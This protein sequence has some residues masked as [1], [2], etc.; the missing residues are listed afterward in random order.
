MYY[1]DIKDK[2]KDA[3]FVLIGLGNELR[4]N[5]ENVL[6]NSKLYKDKSNIIDAISDENV[7]NT[8][9]NAIVYYEIDN[10]VGNTYVEAFRKLYELI[11]DKNYYIIS[12]LMWE[13]PENSGFSC[14]K[15]VSP[16]GSFLRIQNSENN[17]IYDAKPEYDRIIKKLINN[18]DLKDVLP[19]IPNAFV[20]DDYNEDGYL[21][22]WTEYTKWLER[23]LNQKLF[24][25]EIGTDFSMPSVIRWPFEKAV[26]INNKAHMYR[27]CTRFYQLT[28]E[29]KDKAVGIQEEPIKFIN[30]LCRN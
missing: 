18:D 19:L 11:K 4:I 15:I 13:L 22:Q 28:E 17:S 26:Y 3:D 20:H 12:T 8:I 21:Y 16:C 1:K 2:I 9:K 7:K 23:T 29:I 10:G 6:K 30:E 14:S 5:T 24:I 25:L 27:I